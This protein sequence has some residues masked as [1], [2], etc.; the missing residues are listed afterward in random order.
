[1]VLLLP[2]ESWAAAGAYRVLGGWAGIAPPRPYE[3]VL[4]GQWHKAQGRPQES[5]R[6]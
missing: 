6:D 1:M 5:A 3:G 4:E 2:T